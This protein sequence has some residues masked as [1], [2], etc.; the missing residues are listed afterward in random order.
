MDPVKINHFFVK[1]MQ[2]VLMINHFYAKIGLALYI[3]LLLYLNKAI[4][5]NLKI[6]YLLRVTSLSFHSN[7]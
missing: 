6:P 3:N 5:G 1:V 2:P 7:G 4:T